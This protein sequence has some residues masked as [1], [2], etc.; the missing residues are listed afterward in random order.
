MGRNN[1]KKGFNSKV[2]KSRFTANP[3]FAVSDRERQELVEAASALHLTLLETEFG[4]AATPAI[5]C[6][7]L[8]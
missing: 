5:A 6:Q 8:I 7:V 3:V 1:L 4:K 2:N